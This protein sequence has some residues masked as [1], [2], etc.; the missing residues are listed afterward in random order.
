MQAYLC[1]LVLS[2]LLGLD[3]V[4]GCNELVGTVST[5]LHTRH[6]GK[7]KIQCIGQVE[8]WVAVGVHSDETVATQSMEGFTELFLTLKSAGHEQ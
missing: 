7:V 3:R 2:H 6:R 5:V 8:A 4:Q 1:G